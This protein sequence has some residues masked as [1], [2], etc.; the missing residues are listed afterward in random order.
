VIKEG[1]CGGD[2][3]K[4][5]RG[6]HTTRLP[7]AG[8]AFK[9][10]P[11]ESSN[12]SASTHRA[13]SHTTPSSIPHTQN[14]DQTDSWRGEDVPR[15]RSKGSPWALEHIASGAHVSRSA[16]ILCTTPMLMQ[17]S[18]VIWKLMSFTFA[19]MTLPIGTYFFTVSYVFRG[20]CRQVV[21][22]KLITD[23][24]QATQHMQVV[25]Q[26]SWRMSS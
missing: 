4:V 8:F 26:R 21:H 24:A 15:E 5:P 22:L 17:C 9:H 6:L 20:M 3:Q 1:D 18:S 12:V 2:H 14:D 19:M 16:S 23:F 10:G 7:S 13:P 25:S 11:T